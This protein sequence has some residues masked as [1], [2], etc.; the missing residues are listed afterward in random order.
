MA[1]RDRREV[2]NRVKVDSVLQ[3]SPSPRSV[4]GAN[5]PRIYEQAVADAADETRLQRG[6][7]PAQ[8][9]YTVDQILDTGFLPDNDSIQ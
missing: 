4:L 1:K 2:M 8:C 7:F 9:P 3:D 6:S 5:L